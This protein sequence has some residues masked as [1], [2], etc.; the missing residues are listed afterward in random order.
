MTTSDEIWILGA[1]GRTGR[2][3]ARRLADQGANLVL[4]GRDEARLHA[5]GIEARHVIAHDI[6][7]TAAEITRQRP[8]VVINTIGD[9]ASTA[10]TI[11]RAGLPGTHYV[12]LAADLTAVPRLLALHDEAAAAGSTLVTGVGFGVLATEAVVVALCAGRPTPRSVRVDALASVAIEEGTVGTA[13]AASMIDALSAGGRQYANG[14]LTKARIGAEVHTITL[15]DG[16]VVTSMSSPSGELIAAHNASGAPFVVATT[17]F[18]LVG[19]ALRTLLPVLRALV[20]IPVVRRLAI[21]R[22]ARTPIKAAPRPRQHSWGH[23]LVE[24][25]DGTSREGWLRAGEGMDYTAEV[26]AAV[27]TRLANGEGKPGAHT[28]AALFGPDLA[29]VA[30]ATLTLS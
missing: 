11:A 30:G 15:P 7:T 24:W 12:D 14:R 16:E 13:L 17:S 1:T 19:P 28:P 8:A 2:A 20:S 26:V 23:A 27:A 9:Y 10:T 21:A 29:T 4:I 3:T 25:P 6:P 22:I 5:T 18:G